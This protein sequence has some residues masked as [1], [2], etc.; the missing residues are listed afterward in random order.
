MSLRIAHLA[1]L[2]LGYR[3][4]SRQNANGINQREADVAAAFRLAIDDVIAAKP[5]IILIAGDVFHSVRPT[6][7][8][9]LYTFNQFR[10]LRAALAD[11]P[12][13]V[14]AGNHD[15]PRSVET[16]TILTLFE[17]VENVHV[18][19]HETRAIRFDRLE[20]SVTGFPR[21]SLVTG[22][23]RIPPPDPE[24][25]RNIL[26]IHSE[27]AGVVPGD[28]SFA[29]QMGTV[30][31]PGE[32]HAE[33]WD[34]V[35]LGHYHVAAEVMANAWYAGSIEYTSHTPWSESRDGSARVPEGAKGW[36]LVTIEDGDVNVAFKRIP[37][38]RGHIDL[39]PIYCRGMTA[40][41][42]SADVRSRVEAMECDIDGQVVRQVLFDV[43]RNVVRDLDHEILREY[44]TRALHYRFDARR[45]EVKAIS[46]VVTPGR[47]QT[48]QELVAEYLTE[49]VL[50]PGVSRDEILV[51]ADDYLG[52]VERDL[53]ES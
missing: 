19:A 43:P 12:V 8:A 42:I 38:A 50:T 14:I 35:A 32:L 41:E 46:G 17:A 24:A 49:R 48:M 2:H 3:Q 20:L 25:K 18:V 6:N 1:D 34:Y 29:Q 37:L 16:G 23:R 33:Q 22:S 27:I 7:T 21:E 39:Q 47:R 5:D 51:L 36:L 15:T 31:E 11:V 9:I 10:R 28:R 44:K 26:L 52:K 4:Y 13:V 53:A 45:P 30:L 40:E